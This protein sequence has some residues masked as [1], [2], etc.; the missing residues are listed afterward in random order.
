MKIILFVNLF[1]AS[2]MCMAQ[3]ITLHNTRTEGSKNVFIG[4]E[5][6]LI[7]RGGIDN[8]TSIQADEGFIERIGDTLLVKPTSPGTIGILINTKE[9]PVYYEFTASYLPILKV[10]ITDDSPEKKEVTKQAIMTTENIRLISKTSAINDFIDYEVKESIMKI[11]NRIYKSGGNILSF[12][13][14]QA[15][16]RLKSGTNI[17]MEQ[18]TTVSRSTGKKITFRINQNFTVL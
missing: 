1:F 8:I 6:Q 5:N 14:K 4:I 15:I 13:L 10:V 3:S 12:E 9:E 7:L 11:N 16:S 2:C 17:T 18:I